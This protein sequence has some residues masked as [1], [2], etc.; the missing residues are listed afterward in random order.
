MLQ[1]LPGAACLIPS[2]V[3]PRDAA[4]DTA[5]RFVSVRSIV[6]LNAGYT[7]LGRS[8]SLVDIQGPP[9]LDLTAARRLHVRLRELDAAEWSAI[10]TGFDAMRG[11]DIVSVWRHG[12]YRALW[13]ASTV[14]GVGLLTKAVFTGGLLQAEFRARPAKPQSPAEWRAAA[15]LKPPGW[16]E[17]HELLADLLEVA[18]QNLGDD[19]IATEG[20]LIAG[21]TLIH[22][23]RIP[24][25]DV[26][27]AFAP[28]AAVVDLT[29]LISPAV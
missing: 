9:D 3:T 25:K 19:A 8:R 16:R 14:R 10:A 28:F 21:H 22:R 1:R 17:R 2:Q 29:T 5:W 24:A 13:M 6:A 12:G 20:V 23:R 15:A 18:Q 11:D 27:H 4:E 7:T 26:E